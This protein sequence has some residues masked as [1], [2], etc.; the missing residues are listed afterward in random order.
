MKQIRVKELFCCCC[1]GSSPITLP[2]SSLISLI[3]STKITLMF[4]RVEFTI[5]AQTQGQ[6]WRLFHHFIQYKLS[7]V[8]QSMIYSSF[9]FSI[10]ILYL[11]CSEIYRV[12]SKVHQGLGSIQ[13]PRM[14]LKYE[15]NITTLLGIFLGGE[16]RQQG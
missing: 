7:V 11:E 2:I 10:F 16:S 3:D 1:F 9:L 12:P 5:M 8:F 14:C 4:G 6:K 15:C 13:K